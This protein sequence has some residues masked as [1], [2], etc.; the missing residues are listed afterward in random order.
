MNYVSALILSAGLI[1][2]V[3]SGAWIV[4]SGGADTATA[5]EQEMYVSV[6][7]EAS[8]RVDATSVEWM[9]V[10][11]KAGNTAKD[12]YKKL[13]AARAELTKFLLTN[14]LK[15]RNLSYEPVQLQDDSLPL[16]YIATQQIRVFTDDISAVEKLINN[17]TEASENISQI[18]GDR[19]GVLTYRFSVQKSYEDL[20]VA[21]AANAAKNAQA[22]AKLYG[23]EV[24]ITRSTN[25]QTVDG[26]NEHSGP[27]KTKMISALVYA[28]VMLTK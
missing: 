4:K 17:S 11:R 22:L 5:Y 1:V 24:S 19:Y 3:A 10:I 7:G 9:L 26:H 27:T 28:E 23:K 13:D 25:A 14:G 15:E 21:A 2:A 12:S 16:E 18:I 20:Y 8:E 6:I